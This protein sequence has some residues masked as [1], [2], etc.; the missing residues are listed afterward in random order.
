M[1]VGSNDQGKI[2]F[3]EDR[4][5]RWPRVR[6]MAATNFCI[7]SGVILGVAG[8][9]W[10]FLV[11]SDEIRFYLGASNGRELIRRGPGERLKPTYLRQRHTGP[12]PG[13]MVWRVTFYDIRSI[14]M[15][16]PLTLT[17]NLYISLAI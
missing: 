8:L 13:V 9:E 4:G 2:L 16:I 11:F 7:V 17:E 5:S 15:V 14:L 12:T 10:R 3:Q 6:R 1:I